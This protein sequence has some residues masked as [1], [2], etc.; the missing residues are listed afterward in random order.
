MAEYYFF[1]N[2]QYDDSPEALEAIG[3]RGRRIVELATLNIPTSPGFILPNATVRALP[4]TTGKV[5]AELKEP[6]ALTGKAFG[7]G[8]NDSGNPLLVKVVE[9]PMLNIVNTQSIHNIGLCDTTIEGFGAFVGEKFAYHEYC[10]VI[11]HIIDLELLTLKDKERIAKLKAYHKALK[12]ETKAALQ[13]AF[14]SYRDLYPEPIYT[15]AYQQ[16]MF[17]IH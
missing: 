9:S 3:N 10:N 8:F 16:L 6:L 4:R 2:G 5:W 14:K 17:V 1:C 11:Q 13:K 12:G 15:D 7:K